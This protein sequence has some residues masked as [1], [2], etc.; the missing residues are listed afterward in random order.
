MNPYDTLK[1]PA[2]ADPG[3]I[4]KAYRSAAQ[5]AHPDRGGSDEAFHQV[6]L[7][8]DVLSDP[9][10]RDRY[11]RTG[12]CNEPNKADAAE[13]KLAELFASIMDNKEWSGDVIETCR[14]KIAVVIQ[15]L[16]SNIA[17]MTVKQGKLISQAGRIVSTDEFNLYDSILQEK[18]TQLSQQIEHYDNELVLLHRVEVMLE[19][20]TDERPQDAQSAFAAAGVHGASITFTRWD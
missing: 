5:G 8:Y 15:G 20:Y 7:A 10:R 19:V 17:K 1:V 11:D 4:K 13:G 6:Q 16:Q 3:V 2:D 14:K 18:I 9:E 12:D